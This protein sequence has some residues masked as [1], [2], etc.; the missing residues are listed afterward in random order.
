M[1]KN[2]RKCRKKWKSW[3]I[4]MKMK[5][6]GKIWKL[7]RN[8]KEKKLIIWLLIRNWIRKKGKFEIWKNKFLNIN[9]F[10]K[11]WSKNCKMLRKMAKIKSL[12]LINIWWRKI[13]FKRNFKDLIWK[14][15]KK[16]NIWVMKLKDYKKM[17]IIC[18]KN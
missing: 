11:E 6:I 16:K 7:C 15:M 9:K 3:R 12:W 8:K 13:R 18:I 2:I 10:W 14:L 1:K 17:W 5:L 4:P